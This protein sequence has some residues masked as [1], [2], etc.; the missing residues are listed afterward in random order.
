MGAFND[1]ECV[2]YAETCDTGVRKEENTVVFTIRQTLCVAKAFLVYT[3]PIIV[4]YNL[5]IESR[6][7]HK[8]NKY[9]LCTTQVKNFLLLS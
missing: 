1:N 4:M 9:L 7:L 8:K 3:S 6:I 2:N 5:Q